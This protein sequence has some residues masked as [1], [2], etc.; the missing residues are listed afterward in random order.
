MV[1]GIMER[2]NRGESQKERKDGTSLR[3]GEGVLRLGKGT[4]VGIGDKGMSI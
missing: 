1:S 4:R 3:G 2:L